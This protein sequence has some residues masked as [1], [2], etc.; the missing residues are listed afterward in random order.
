MTLTTSRA[1]GQ[2]VFVPDAE[3]RFQH[4][5][6]ADVDILPRVRANKVQPFHGGL[7]MSRVPM[8]LGVARVQDGILDV[9]S[10]IDHTR[11]SG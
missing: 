7:R 9:S 5:I 10:P 1:A 4:T 3:K 8:G 11:V 2:D 6:D